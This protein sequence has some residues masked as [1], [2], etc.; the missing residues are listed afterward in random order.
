MCKILDPLP[1]VKIKHCDYM[2]DQDRVRVDPRWFG[3]LDPNPGLDWSHTE[4]NK[5]DPDPHE[6]NAYLAG[7]GSG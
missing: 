1:T 7:R 6:T 5:L 2:S 4:L 3:S